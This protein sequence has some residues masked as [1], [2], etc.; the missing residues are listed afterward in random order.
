MM[1]AYVSGGEIQITM[2]LRD[3]EDIML[4]LVEMKSQIRYYRSRGDLY[5]DIEGGEYEYEPRT[6]DFLDMLYEKGIR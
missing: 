6:Q 1:D 4:D 3:L 2:D 5:G